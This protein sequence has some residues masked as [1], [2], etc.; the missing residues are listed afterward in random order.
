MSDLKKKFEVMDYLKRN[1][2]K[3]H[4]LSA[5][6][7]RDEVQYHVRYSVQR[8]PHAQDDGRR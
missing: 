4:N 1:K 8:V 2:S 6:K 3:F 5:R 7:V